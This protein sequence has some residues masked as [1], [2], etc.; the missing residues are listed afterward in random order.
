MSASLFEDKIVELS[1]FELLLDPNSFRLIDDPLWEPIPDHELGD[2]RVQAQAYEAVLQESRTA[3]RELRSSLEAHGWLDFDPLWVRRVG[4]GAFV[5]VDGNRR[6][7]AWRSLW[8]TPGQR[9]LF[10]GEQSTRRFCVRVLAG[11][12]SREGSLAL[13]LRHVSTTQGWPA[14]GATV[15]RERHQ[16]QFG[17][18]PDSQSYRSRGWRAAVEPLALELARY[19]VREYPRDGT[20]QQVFRLLLEALSTRG[21]REWLT[22][23]GHQV[24]EARRDRLFSWMVAR[25]AV[26][27][28]SSEDGAG[29]EQQRTLAF[30]VGELRRLPALLEQPELLRRLDAGARLGEL[31][32][33]AHA[34][35]FDEPSSYLHPWVDSRL[36]SRGPLDTGRGQ[37]ALWSL[38]E[39][40]KRA[41]EEPVEPGTEHPWP[42]HR[43]ALP[44]ALA[45]LRL[46][47]FRGLSGASLSDFRRLN[48]VVGINNA[49]KTSVLE[50]LYLLMRMSDPRGLF[51]I[52]RLRTRHDPESKPSWLSELVSGLA[53]DLTA[54][55]SSGRELALKLGQLELANG[56][57]LATALPGLR[58]EAEFDGGRQV[59]RTEL[60]SHRPRR[61]RIVEGEG[62]WLAPVVL[63]S[64]YAR[65]ELAA[66]SRS[67]EN[68]VEQQSLSVI[69]DA[70]RES[71]DEGIVDVRLVS[72]SGRFLVEHESR[73][74]MDLANYGE[75]LQRIFELGLLFAGCR[76]GLVLIDELETAIH[77]SAMLRFARM[78]RELAAAFE[79]QVFLTT[80]SKEAVDAFLA[81]E[82]GVEQLAA[83]LL[84]GE[85]NA[86]RV[87]RYDGVGLRRAL[88]V[89]D[90]DIRRL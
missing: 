60:F 5:I 19:F 35:G 3:M 86:E 15:W 76:G 72:E 13:G 49:G 36:E 10:E 31:L 37:R 45:T 55:D 16:A 64:P 85:G 87:Q 22:D 79:V 1:P 61:T 70:L 73:S 34:P 7:V 21:L 32:L 53:V 41:G 8:H 20:G 6:L 71:V 67:Y 24:N 40:L 47:H 68:S 12:L 30:D 25:D 11:P 77:P 62:V 66:V 82:E 14:L 9:S 39:G 51:D 2:H 58:L 56:A 48:L 80:H 18:F 57:D 28:S 52:L 59:S 78:L 46:H 43:S 17:E 81:D 84:R 83:Y 54:I 65:R 88:E 29:R 74:V 63:H 90:V 50:A 69:V 26:E 33:E 27:L 23:A 42:L 75:G 4:Q 44:L 38:R 89:A